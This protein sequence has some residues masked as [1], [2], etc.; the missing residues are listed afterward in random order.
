VQRGQT[1]IWDQQ[2]FETAVGQRGRRSDVPSGSGR[3]LDSSSRA[4]ARAN[5]ARGSEERS[6]RFQAFLPPAGH[7]RC[8]LIGG[9]TDRRTEGPPEILTTT[10]QAL[11]VGRIRLGEECAPP[12]SAS[13]C[14]QGRHPPLT[15]IGHQHRRAI[16]PQNH[17][18]S[19]P[20]KLNRPSASGQ[21]SAL[22]DP[23]PA[24]QH[25]WIWRGSGAAHAGG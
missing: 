20:P 1:V 22:A 23:D 12:L 13:L 11:Q 25:C 6:C 24:P 4:P 9:A 7:I 10:C 21:G 18:L 3:V 8:N 15:W 5:T 2:T 17:T 14:W 19:P 16:A